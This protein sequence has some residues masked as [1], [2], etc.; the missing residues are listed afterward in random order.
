MSSFPNFQS[1]SYYP[2][3]CKNAVLT[4]LILLIQDQKILIFKLVPMTKILRSIHGTSRCFI[5][6]LKRGI[7]QFSILKA[8]WD[9][10]FSCPNFSLSNCNLLQPE[11]DKMITHVCSLIFVRKAKLHCFSSCTKLRFLYINKIYFWLN[12][13]NFLL[14]SVRIYFNAIYHKGLTYKQDNYHRRLLQPN[15]FR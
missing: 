14:I 2:L 4:V 1:N 11:M 5:V 6:D 13:K 3:F 10:F 8:I 15:K 7:T 9:A 12:L